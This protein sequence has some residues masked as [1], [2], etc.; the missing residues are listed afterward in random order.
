MKLLKGQS[1]KEE[2]RFRMP[3]LAL[4]GFFVSALAIAVGL[5]LSDAM[6]LVGGATILATVIAGLYDLNRS[7]FKRRG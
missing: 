5:W 1:I 4:A 2:R 7:S 6:L 3:A